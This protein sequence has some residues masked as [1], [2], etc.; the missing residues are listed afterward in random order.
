MLY[1]T[2]QM[3]KTSSRMSKMI[4][5]LQGE[6]MKSLHYHFRIGHSTICQ[7]IP[8]VCDVIYNKLK[9]DFVKVRFTFFKQ[10][11]D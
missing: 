6:T 4:S 5:V 9:Q 1:Y 3:V 2:I 8:E 11:R 10:Y 7:L